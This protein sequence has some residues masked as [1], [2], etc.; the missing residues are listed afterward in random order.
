MSDAAADDRAPDLPASLDYSAEFAPDDEWVFEASGPSLG[1]RVAAEALGTFALVLVGLGFAAFAA[2]SYLEVGL[3]YGL[4]LVVGTLMVGHISGAHFNPAVSVAQWIAGRLRATDLPFY[5]ISQVVGAILGAAVVLVLIGYDPTVVNAKDLLRDLAVGSNPNANSFPIA[6]G[7][8][9]E[10][11]FVALFVAVVLF[12]T[13]IRAAKSVGPWAIGLAFTLLITLSMRFTN[14]GLN[15][16]RATATA[17]LAHDWSL[18]QLWMWWVAPLV[19]AVVVGV[20]YRAFTPE[21]ELVEEM[22]F[23]DL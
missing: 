11:L 17:V 8:I 14:G 21:E 9:V 20:L 23:E 4:V 15:P 7:L 13:S 18:N 12:A 2:R 19:G 5:L 6:A 3:G 10:S 16:A 22:V 1:A